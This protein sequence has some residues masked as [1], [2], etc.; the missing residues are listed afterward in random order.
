MNKS[1]PDFRRKRSDTQIGTI[2]KQY[3]VNFDARSDMKLGRYLKEK[4][5]PSLSK[6]LERVE[7]ATKK[8]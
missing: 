8:K 3:G 4:G 7:R 2:E 5:F 6:A 1:K